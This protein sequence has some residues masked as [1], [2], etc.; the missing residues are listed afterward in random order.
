VG[1]NV[2]SGVKE[3]EFGMEKRPEN[4][5]KENQINFQVYCCHSEIYCH[6]GSW[7]FLKECDPAQVTKGVHLKK[8]R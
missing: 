7:P 8:R 3:N 6:F 1:E 5:G 2:A 4:I